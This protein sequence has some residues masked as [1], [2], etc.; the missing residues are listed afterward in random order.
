MSAPHDRPALLP[1]V[2]A[3]LGVF[4]LMALLMP[5]TPAMGDAAELILALALA[6]IPHPTG[7]PLYVMAGT[8]FV[9]AAHALGISWVVAANLWSVTGA[10]VAAAAYT[11]LV[12][13]LVAALEDDARLAAFRGGVRAVAVAFPVIALA[14]NPVWIDAATGAEVYSWNCALL[15]LGAA[16]MLGR[17]RATSAASDAGE[18]H[19]ALA[20]GL[21]CGA[22]AAHH[23]TSL[24]FVLPMTVALVATLVRAG[25]WR[26]SLA[27]TGVVASLIPLASYGWIAWRAAHPAPFQW[28]VEPRW[29]SWWFHVRAALYTHYLGRFA[30]TVP[31]WTLI[32]GGLLV[33]ILPGMSLGA[34][35]ALRTTS[36]PARWGLLAL[37]GGAA[38]QVVF[39]VS[40]GVPDAAMYLLPAL[41]ASLSVGAPLLL[42]LAR[43][44]SRAVAFAAAAG[45]VLALAA[46]SV[47]RALTERLALARVDAGFRK[48]WRSIPF[49]RGIVLWADDHYHRFLAL[50]LLEGQRPGLYME[51]PDMLVWHARREA[52]R[53]RFGF[54]PLEGLSLRTAKDLEEI[55]TNVRRRAK[56]PVLVLPQ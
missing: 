13:H 18:T 22:C 45:L 30:P 41:L 48:A 36:R 7:Y 39:V 35:F 12:Q 26:A 5:S 4:A 17:L 20:W 37:L 2:V 28:P 46:W 9:R 32:K 23:V 8:L 31:E 6:G 56:V 19:A 10:A 54:D 3:G 33:W 42:W 38:L 24:L 11:R 53:R 15:A 27:L 16:F 49:E 21:L 43:R 51:N 29:S 52:F 34:L 44:T 40:Y 47:P 14:L 55:P 50:Q 25:R 1:P